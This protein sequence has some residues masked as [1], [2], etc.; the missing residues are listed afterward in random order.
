MF[1]K[2]KTLYDAMSQIRN[3]LTYILSLSRNKKT[4][5]TE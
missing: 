4:H 5:F 3:G 1:G 2:L